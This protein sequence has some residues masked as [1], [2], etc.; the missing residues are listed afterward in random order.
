MV[1]DE[2]VTQFEIDEQKKGI[3][4]QMKS[5]NVTPPAPDVLDKQLLD[6]LITDR[7]IVQF[8]QTAWCPETHGGKYRR[9]AEGADTSRLGKSGRHLVAA[10]GLPTQR[11]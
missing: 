2:A 9:T 1:N 10:G 4:A 8:A 6:R 11:A 5:Q 7:A 3:L